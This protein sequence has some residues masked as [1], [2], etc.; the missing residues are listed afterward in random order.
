VRQSGGQQNE[1]EHPTAIRSECVIRDGR[2]FL[3][4]FFFFFLFPGF[5]LAGAARE[6]KAAD[7]ISAHPSPPPPH[8][9]K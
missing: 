2:E 3:F 8:T 6:K 7:G 9:E 4:F 1:D 5:A